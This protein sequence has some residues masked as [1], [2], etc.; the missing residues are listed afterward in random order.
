MLDMTSFLTVLGG[1]VGALALYAFFKSERDPGP[2]LFDLKPFQSK[3]P[4]LSN[5]LPWATLMDDGVVTTKEG[6]LLTGWLCQGQDIASLSKAERD[7]LAGRMNAGLT[8]ALGDGWA[9]WFDAVRMPAASYPTSDRYHFTDPVTALINEERRQQFLAEGAHYET[10]QALYLQYLPPMASKAAWGAKMV[11]G[12]ERTSLSEQHRATLERVVISFEDHL[13]DVLHLRRMGGFDYDDGFGTRHHQDELVNTLHYLVT[14][15]E[16]GVNIPAG[17]PYL[18]GLIGGQEL[19]TGL[20]PKLG[21]DYIACVSIEGFPATSYP[22]MLNLLVDLPFAYR[23]SM[24]FIAL[25]QTSADPLL[26]AFQRKWMQKQRGLVDQLFKIQGVVNQDAVEMT[27]QAEAAMSEA[28]SGRVVFGFYTATIVL[29]GPDQAAL[30]QH[31]RNLARQI[32]R[33]GFAARLETINTLEAWLG[34]LPGHTRPNV[35]QPILHSLNVA[36]L[37]PASGT[38]TGAATCPSPLFPPNSPPLLHATTGGATPLRINL[39]VGDVGHTLLFGPTG[40]G[41]SVMLAN[42]AQSWMGYKG[43]RVTAFDKGWSM[44]ALAKGVGGAHY[45]L[46]ADETSPGLCPL[47]W[48]DSASDVA[49]AEEWLAACFELQLK[50]APTPAQKNEIHKAILSMRQTARTEGRSLSDFITSVQDE[51]VREALRPYT[52]DGPLGDLLDAHL[53]GLADSRFAVFEL[54]ELMGRGDAVAVPV[55]LYL[56]RRFEKSLTGQPALLILDEAWIMLGHPVFREKLREWLKTL[57]KANCAVVIATQ[58]LS[59]A[60]RSGLLDV[61]QESCPTKIFLPNAEAFQ[62]GS[63]EV[64]GPYDLYKGLG[65][66]DTEIGIIADA[67]P[68][69]E[70]YLTSPEGRRLAQ[71]RL[72]PIALA[73]TAASSRDDI[74]AIKDLAEREGE[75]LPVAWLKQKGVKHDLLEAA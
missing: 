32:N 3:A 43:A 23:V 33:G 10:Q 4:A 14:G 69:R 21:E 37:L 9:I 58:S 45:A 52:I 70:F 27:G 28:S 13:G 42:L 46:G 64:L 57:R 66:N 68:K 22:F 35:R 56:F 31:G 54:D 2:K 59:D 39:H 25:D 38:Y 40:A 18:D 1:V 44:F 47:A 26:A 8:A 71:L 53:D 62:R 34:T 12:G 51:E 50:R 16:G 63:S 67:T 17:V 5:L 29:R 19:W 60:W 61:L 73:F 55:L 15:S 30:V 65:L 36:H 49:W 48:L 20:T 7:R 74:A 72:G 41:K 11:D 24:R 6:A 75:N